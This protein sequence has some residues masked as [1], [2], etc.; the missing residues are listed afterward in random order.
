MAAGKSEMVLYGI[1]T[2]DPTGHTRRLLRSS[3]PA[4][5]VESVAQVSLGIGPPSP[6]TAKQYVIEDDAN[7]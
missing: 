7:I 1:V 2:V 6:L 4:T 5:A 3:A